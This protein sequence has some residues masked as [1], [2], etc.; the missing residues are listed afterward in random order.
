MNM[1]G[2]GTGNSRPVSRESEVNMKL[3]TGTGSISPWA[4]CL[5]ARMLPRRFIAWVHV[6][7][8]DGQD[9]RTAM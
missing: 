9:A 5:P 7:A 6:H 3:M 4:G 1:E 2:K 8:G